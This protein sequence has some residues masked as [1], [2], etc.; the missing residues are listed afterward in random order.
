MPKR[1]EDPDPFRYINPSTF[2]LF[3]IVYLVVTILAS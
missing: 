1:D 3:L 2:Y